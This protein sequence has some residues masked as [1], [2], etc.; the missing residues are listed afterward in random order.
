MLYQQMHS[1]IQA[2]PRD[3][4]VPEVQQDVLCVIAVE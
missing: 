1:F 3:Y 4:L 2:I